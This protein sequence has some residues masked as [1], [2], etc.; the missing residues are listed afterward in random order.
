MQ[1]STEELKQVDPAIMSCATSTK[2]TRYSKQ[3]LINMRN[4]KLSTIKPECLFR[5]D[6]VMLAIAR[7]AEN[8]ENLATHN[9]PRP[10]IGLTQW[11]PEI[12]DFIKN[13]KQVTGLNR[14]FIT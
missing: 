7:D 10:Y 3:E 6:I 14:K 12:F 5:K 4:S 8:D 13:F 1:K 11:N 9:N 2:M